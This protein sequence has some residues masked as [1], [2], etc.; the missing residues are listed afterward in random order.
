MPVPLAASIPFSDGPEP[1][2]GVPE[3]YDGFLTN[4]SL[5]FSLQPRTFNTEAARVAFTITH[6]TGQARLWGTAE[7]EWQR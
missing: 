4:C 5:L 1:R 6:L 2:V 3:R 7:W